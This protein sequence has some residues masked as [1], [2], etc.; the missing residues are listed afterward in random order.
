MPITARLGLFYV[1][2]FIGT[3]VTGPYIGA[4]FNA[5]G[6]SGK[7][8]GVI[9]A[10][11]GMARVFTGPM[12]AVW[13]DGF[14]LR[15]TPM[16]ILG[17]AVTLLYVAFAFSHGFWAWAA[18][19]FV[20]QSLFGALS[21][22]ADVI[23]LRRAA[24]DG[25]NYGFPRGIGSVGF[26]F[27]NIAMGIILTLTAPDA[28]VVWMT[29]AAAAVVIGGR[30]LLPPDPVHEDGEIA[31]RTDRWRGLGD[32]LRDPA[33]ML[34]MVSAGLV[35]AS[36]GFYYGFSVLSW[37][38]QGLPPSLSGTLWGVGVGTEVLFFWFGEGFRRAIGPERLLMLGA[39]GAVVRWTCLAFSPPLAWLFPLQMLHA[40]TYCATFMASLRLIERL[41]PA[42]SASAAQSLN[43]VFSGGLLSGLSSIASGALFDAAGPG[44]YFAMAGL[45]LAGLA[46][47][48]A[49]PRVA[50]GRTAY[51]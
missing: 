29:A 38:A 12:L 35:Q 36:H 31:H 41:T 8:I 43:S 37:K 1:A 27:A 16:I 14:R 46:G 13:A 32:L 17:A 47:A 44:G 48:I 7:E 20:S 3:G 26:V 30:W 11:P 45:A 51:A 15:R 25:F 22:L 4:W 34:A 24:R 10:A 18:L 9:L 33:F 42:K 50:A 5:H 19:W 49:L 39:A 21:P 6:L 23:A 2:I 40:L 28:V